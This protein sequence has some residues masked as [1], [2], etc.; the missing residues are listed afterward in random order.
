MTRWMIVPGGPQSL[1]VFARSN[2]VYLKNR[3][4]RFAH[5]NMAY[6]YVP[7]FLVQVVRLQRSQGE[8]AHQV[9]RGK[10]ALALMEGH[11]R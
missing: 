5:E 8:A 6:K 1:L 4:L 11:L 2:A 3:T 7:R 9:S 10:T